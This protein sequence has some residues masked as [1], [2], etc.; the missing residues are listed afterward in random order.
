MGNMGTQEHD[1]LMHAHAYTS[2][3]IYIVLRL[4]WDHH[5]ATPMPCCA[6]L[7]TTCMMRSQ[8]RTSR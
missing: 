3:C 1:A 7:C 6:G 8:R 4:P 2:C 5:H